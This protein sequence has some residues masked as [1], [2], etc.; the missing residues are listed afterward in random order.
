VSSFRALPAR[1]VLPLAAGIAILCGA[2]A[3]GKKGPP[4]APLRPVPTMAAGFSIERAGTAV[5]LRFTV[6]DGNLDG[7]TPPAADRVDLFG[8]S[9]AADA[10]PPT[11]AELLVPAN[12][13]KSIAVRPPD[14]S[15]DASNATPAP[16]PEAKPDTRPAPGEAASFVETVATP[17][18]ATPMLRYYAA[19]S[20]AGRR[21]GPLSPVLHVPLSVSPA[22]PT[23]VSI[24]YDERTLTAV[25]VAASP[26]QQFV[27]D[28]T[29][30]AGAPVK[31]ASP[32]PFDAPKLELPVAFG[33]EVCLVV[34]AVEIRES[35]SLIGPATATTCVTPVDRFAPPP[36]TGLF[37]AG[38]EGG[39]DLAWTA[40][41][42]PDLAGYLVLRGDNPDGTLQPLMTTAVT[43]TTY[44]DQ[45]AKAG[46]SY[47]Y[48]VVA[49]DTAAPP[50]RSR[51]SNRQVATAR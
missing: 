23:G 45:T 10:P 31:R 48:A 43:G 44:R 9:K 19:V 33:Q 46:V 5:T 4:Q 14:A 26:G 22:S 27:V 40:S 8:L 29:D 47:V 28:L 34:R 32:S 3:C 38:G 30:R 11:P 49:I 18:P 51:E 41:S 1:R 35:V 36:P 50:N 24:D 7:S 37:A 12:L 39:V 20:A 13:L 2:W 16:K 42:A 6:P 17:D 25:W 15:P 21:R